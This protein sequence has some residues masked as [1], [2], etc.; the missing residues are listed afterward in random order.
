MHPP[1]PTPHWGAQAA[2]CQLPGACTTSRSCGER[3]WTEGSDRSWQESTGIRMLLSGAGPL[4]RSK[5]QLWWRI[6]PKSHSPW[7]TVDPVDTWWSRAGSRTRRDTESPERSLVA[8]GRRTW[9]PPAS[10]SIQLTVNSWL[11][12]SILELRTA[13]SLFG[14]FGLTLVTE[15][16]S[17]SHWHVI[18]T[19]SYH[20]LWWQYPL[21][22]RPTFRGPFLCLQLIP[23]LLLPP[24]QF[25]STLCTSLTPT[26]RS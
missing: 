10:S 14:I 19:D 13:P 20:Q 1:P 22:N 5:L 26:S 12:C 18:A 8:V 9:H 17:C 25:I 24:L 15:N 16:V 6:G 11:L 3:A 4:L 21:R 23:G 7:L 2:H